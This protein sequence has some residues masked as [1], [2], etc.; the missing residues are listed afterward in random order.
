MIRN[1]RYIFNGA[2]ALVRKSL[3]LEWFHSLFVAVPT[4]FLLLVVREFFS[5]AP[6]QQRLW[7][8]VAIMTGLLLVQLL[9]SVRTF[10]FTNNMTY[11]LST[12]LRMK[13]GRHLQKISMGAFRQRDPGDLASV[14]L[15]DVANFELIFGHTVGSLI[16]A[17]FAFVIVSVFLFITDWR[18][19]LILWLALPLVWLL[20]KVAT[21]L[22]QRPGVQHIEAR[23]A[24]G[25]RFLEYV[26]GIRHIKSYGMTGERFSTLQQAL[27]DFRRA[28]IRTEGIP[29]PFILL[30][31]A[32]LEACF[33]LMIL[34][35]VHFFAGGS[36]SVPALVAF[37]IM[38]YRLYEP[39]KIVLVDYTL[40]RYMNISMG[41]IVEVLETP[42]QQGGLAVRPAG[43]DIRFENVDFCY[44]PGQQVL[45]NVSFHIPE[46]SLTALV[47]PS[48]SGKTTITSL[49]A[50]FWDVDGGSIKI[51]GADI[52]DMEPAAVYSLISE[53]FQEVYLFDDTI[54]NNIR[55][56]NPQ[57]TY[58]QV[59]DA[60]DRALVMEFAWEMPEGINSR[61]GENGN[62][63]SGGQ[64]QRISIARA[65]LKD[66]PIVL[67]DEAT[68]SLDPENEV[69]IQQAIQ[70]LV[71][72]KTVIVIAH[73]LSTI[74]RADQIL[75]LKDGRVHESGRHATLLER[76]GLY[77]K[78]WDIQQRAGGWKLNKEA[79]Y[80][81]SSGGSVAAG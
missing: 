35:G 10:T 19:A 8:Y 76:K 15:Q 68:A 13:L 22:M 21:F 1:L 30:A 63:L 61:V 62:R 69:Q 14:V 11:T 38:G 2:P 66:A 18:L 34:A 49:I 20:V 59:I 24:T 6:D 73:K 58:E 81:Q 36:L 43:G 77:A 7:T 27:D 46:K 54:Y 9:V 48:G 55:Y 56:G 17:V 57:A 4:G 42:V 26:T 67:L 41:R 12:I 71:K 51:G 5:P 50:R 39:I 74:I 45:H 40:L 16:S 78:L 53:V 3:L 72:E 80:E 70:Q 44:L 64:K 25:A 47:G 37:L 33:L 75:V 79:V 32:V 28:S 31:A 29:G 23:N 60:A 65:L 52:R